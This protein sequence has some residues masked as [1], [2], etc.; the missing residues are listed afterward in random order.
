MPAY[1]RFRKIIRYVA[2]LAAIVLAAGTVLTGVF[3]VESGL[4]PG[5]L[6]PARPFSLTETALARSASA[7]LDAE[8][9]E[10]GALWQ[11][12]AFLA[13][14]PC[15]YP[16]F[17]KMT[18]PR[19]AHPWTTWGLGLSE[20][21]YVSNDRGY[22][23][24]INQNNTGQYS[25][26][27]CGPASVTMACMW[28]DPYF[29]HSTEEARATF[30]SEG[31][32]WYMDDIASYLEMYGIPCREVENQGSQGIMN[33]LRRGRIIII[34]ID[35][36]ELSYNRNTAQHVDKFY[37][38]GSGHFIIIKGF[39]LVDGKVF[40]ECYDPAT[41]NYYYSFERYT[42]NNEPMGRDRYYRGEEIQ[43]AMY[44]W[45]NRYLVIEPRY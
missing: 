22:A 2:A 26:E 23:W 42:S 18:L 34:N 10:S 16:E 12:R 6:W 9:M 35:L 25:Y 41:Q 43:R 5:T 36:R 31:G 28:S 32:W 4:R 14:I 27:N 1:T 29:G 21:E 20:D 38:G 19:P 40:F 13:H 15:S 7:A 24:Y 8:A 44:N 39:A 45:Y 33:Q 3:P 17:E 30:H 11:A 37:N